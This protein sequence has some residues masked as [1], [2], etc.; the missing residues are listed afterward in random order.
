MA[1]FKKAID[2]PGLPASYKVAELKE[3]FDGLA[4]VHISRYI[5]RDDHEKALEEAIEKLKCEHGSKASTAEEML[6]ELLAGETI[7]PNDAAG[8][9]TFVSTLEETYF[10]AVETNR[11]AEFH[12][13]SLHKQIIVRKLAFLK[14]KFATQIAERHNTRK[15]WRF[16]AFLA[17][18]TVHK[19]MS[20]EMQELETESQKL[21][22]TA[23]TLT[24]TDSEY[25]V[26][27]ED[28]GEGKDDEE[29]EKAGSIESWDFEIAS[30][31][32]CP[33]A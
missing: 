16:E 22:R 11:D 8:V 9:N 14:K 21:V 32:D 7:E 23:C 5:R 3:W 10:L 15:A 31:P 26:E 30:V 12:R 4:R 28:N 13:K 20:T 24:E 6:E 33:Y 29:E 27:D 17:L 1:Q 25:E 19:R 18:L 2:L